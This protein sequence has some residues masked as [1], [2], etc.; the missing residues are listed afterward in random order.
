LSKAIALDMDGTTLD[1]DFNLPEKNIVSIK[2]LQKAGIKVIIAT[3]RIFEAAYPFYKKLKLDTPLICYNGAKIYD[4]S[5]NCIYSMDLSKHEVKKIISAGDFKNN[6][7]VILFFCD[8]KVIAPFYDE[9]VREY[10]E[11]TRTKAVI[12]PDI[13]E[14]PPDVAKIIFSSLNYDF[15]DSVAEKLRKTLGDRVYITNSMKRYIEFLNKN[16]SKGKAIEFV[17]KKIGIP[18]EQFVVIGDNNNDLK[19]FLPQVFKVAV[20][21]GTEELKKQADMITL[22]NDESG[23]SYAVEKIFFSGSN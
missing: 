1:S 9:N 7:A 19:M 16:I 14:N 22:T 3:G 12:I 18:L 2:K 11:R 8:D 6:G 20:K 4:K 17:S 15:L 21:N 10:E 13:A 5:G 23:V